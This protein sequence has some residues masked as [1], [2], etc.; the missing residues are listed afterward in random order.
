MN[1]ATFDKAGNFFY[2]SQVSPAP[3]VLQY[4]VNGTTGALTAAGSFAVPANPA[5]MLV[6][7][8][9]RFLYVSHIHPTLP[10]ANLVSAFS[11][12]AAAGI[13]GTLAGSPFAAGQYPTTLLVN[14]AG[15]F[16]YAVNTG[17]SGS[18]AV[19]GAGS[20]SAWLINGATGALIPSPGS[21][22]ATGGGNTRD[23]TI[24]PTGR[25]LVATNSSSG[26]VAAFTINASTGALTHAT[27]SPM[28]PAVGISPG[29]GIFDP[30]GRFMYLDDA[31]TNSVSS[32]AFNAATGALTLIGSSP[33]G[34]TPT[35]RPQIAGLQ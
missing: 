21:P 13:V 17:L 34:N 4:S 19:A 20:V 8:A 29:T 31:G 9:G 22:I 33:A 30:S 6:E 18:P 10:A 16:L 1:D 26:T 35:T 14:R 32:Y 23:A 12:S 15:Q 2:A 25:Y 28:S 27:G 7:P 5:A 24:D 3:L 11:I